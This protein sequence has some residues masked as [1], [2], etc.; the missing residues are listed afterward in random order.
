MK[1]IRFSIKL[2]FLGWLWTDLS[3]VLALKSVYYWRRIK[4]AG[5]DPSSPAADGRVTVG[6]SKVSYLDNVRINSLRILKTVLCSRGTLSLS[7]SLSLSPCSHPP[8]IPA[9]IFSSIPGRDLSQ[10]YSRQRS[11]PALFLFIGG[12]HEAQQRIPYQTLLQLSLFPMVSQWTYH[13]LSLFP[14]VVVS[15]DMSPTTHRHSVFSGESAWT[16]GN[17]RFTFI[18]GDNCGFKLRTWPLI[19]RIRKDGGANWKLQ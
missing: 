12:L 18:F 11:I 4:W 2:T 14:I 5:T 3:A 1:P 6:G 16:R 8:C 9:E 10:L 19:M 13:Q 7:L 17:S 15:H